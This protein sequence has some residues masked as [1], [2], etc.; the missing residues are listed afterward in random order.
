MA[1]NQSEEIASRAV[2]ENVMA[3]LEVKYP[4]GTTVPMPD[5]WVVI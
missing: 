1:S 4:E 3:E 5:F 2:I